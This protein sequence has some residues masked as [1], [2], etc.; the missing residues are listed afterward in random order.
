MSDMTTTGLMRPYPGL[1]SFNPDE[2]ELFFGRDDSIHLLV[3]TLARARFLAVL[4]SSG[5]GK[6]SIVKTG[7]LDALERGLMEG[8]GARWR[9][10]N[11]RPAGSPLKK[12]TEGLLASEPRKKE[13]SETEVNILRG[14]LALGPRS[15]IEW[16][17]DGNLPPKTNLLLLVDQF[18]ELFRYQD[19]AEKEESEAFTSLLLECVHSQEFPI[20]V[21]LTMRSEYLGACSLMEGLAETISRGMVLTPRMTREHCRKAILGPASVCGFRIEEPLVNQLL[22]D[23]ANFAPWD[24]RGSADQLDRLVRRA[25]QLPLL[26][27]TLNRL[28]LDAAAYESAGKIQ[29]RLS[30]YKV[31]GGLSGALDTHGNHLLDELTKKGL[32]WAVERIFRALI[33]GTSISD[34]VRRPQQVGTL[35]E[36]CSGDARAVEDVLHIFCAPGCNFLTPELHDPGPEKRKPLNNDLW[37]DISHESL[38]RQ[39]KKMT[40]WLRRESM[41][42]QYWRRLNDRMVDGEPLRGRELANLV[43]WRDEMK[44]SETWAKRYGGAFDDAMAFLNKSQQ[45]EDARR[46][47]R[48]VLIASGVLIEVLALASVAI[49]MWYRAA[50]AT[51]KLQAA[52]VAL[53]ETNSALNQKGAQLRDQYNSLQSRIAGLEAENAELK[54]KAAATQG[55]TA[56]TVYLGPEPSGNY[57]DEATDEHVSPTDRLSNDPNGTPISIPGG[58]VLTTRRLYD[59]FRSGTLKGGSG[60]DVPFV[61]IDVRDGTLPTLPNALRLPGVGGGVTFD[62]ETQRTLFNALSKSVK[63]FSD[64]IVFFGD[65][66]KSWA[67]YNAAL[68]AIQIGYPNV[69]WYRGGLASWKAANLKTVQ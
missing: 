57:A 21:V 60:A 33:Q 64:G 66:A 5:T 19:Y 43:A 42:G 68:R 32:G 7:L 38:I 63:N 55:K 36:L 50:E 65:G 44:P 62:D 9:V 16:C 47:G 12:L 49:F 41:A 3:D 13:P 51:N 1:R 28:W 40:D 4:G 15:V 34:A 37:I 11:F 53:Q 69:Y 30:D 31:I 2:V 24:E 27:Y 35:I 48:V 20:Y 17:R 61:L 58:V 10:V 45:T 59:A 52:I 18:E 26:Q 22:N 39:W 56:S 23:L 54:G 14:F 25:D 6:S 67:P 8:A 46:R 29:L